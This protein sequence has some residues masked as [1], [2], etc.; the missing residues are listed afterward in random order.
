MV[1]GDA[2]TAPAEKR[3]VFLDR[4]VGQRLVA[5]DVQAAHGHR[6]WMEG[7]QLLAVDRQL[8][9]FTREALV[10]H[11]RHFGA[12]QAHPFGATLLR[13]RH[14]GQQAGV[15]PQRHA[16]PVEG[17]AR[18]FTQGIQALGEL[19]LLLHHLAKLLAHDFAG[20]GE[21]FAVIA[22]DHQI[23]AIDLGVREV[24]QAHDRG[25]AHGPCQN[26]NVGVAGTLNRHQA[27]QFAF[28]HLAQHG[29]GQFFA[30]QNRVVGVNQRLLPLFL[31]ISQQTATE[32]LD[33]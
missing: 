11:E 21:D 19:T 23:D 6:Q 26:R 4:E 20:V 30:D 31:Q 7:G 18:Q 12:V 13:P 27:D 9:L 24:H 29:R 28:R 5:T 15:D 33:V 1:E 17:D 2:N 8:F 25:N 32:V 16:M 22:V 14:V 3:V 10:D